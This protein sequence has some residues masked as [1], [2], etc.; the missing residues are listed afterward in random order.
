MQPARRVLLND[1]GEGCRG[2]LARWRFTRRLRRFPEIALAAILFERH[3]AALFCGDRWGF[4]LG[5]ELER[6][7]GGRQRTGRHIGMIAE[8]GPSF[9]TAPSRL[10]AP[11]L[12]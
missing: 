12:V 4:W 2:L 11:G 10:C 9:Q 1:E 8:T 7:T 5:V 6:G 3:A